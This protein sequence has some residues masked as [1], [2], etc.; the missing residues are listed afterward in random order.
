MFAELLGRESGYNKGR[1]G[2]MHIA[3]LE[4]G[5]FGAN[6]IVGAGSP[7]ACGAAHMFKLRGEARV[8]VPFFGDG[9]MNQGVLL[10]SLNL[11]V[12][13]DLPVVFVCEN[14]GYAIT[15]PIEEMAR[16]ELHVRAAG[17]GMAAEAVDGMDVRA[18][19]RAAAKAVARARAGGGP[20][21]LECRAY[22]YSLHNVAKGVARDDDRPQAEQAAWRARDAIE[23][24][25][26]ELTAERLWDDGARAEI[27][28]EVERELDGAIAFARNS[29]RPDPEA[30]LDHMYAV[31]YPGLPAWGWE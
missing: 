21:F 17:F 20:S 28:A 31:T 8:A 9:A 26:G 4:L 10:E 11:A 27:D 24:L 6:G 14:N 1:G 19:Y 18:V 15:S 12:V 7:M 30:A 2:S 3:D 25:A 22:R 16:G 13:L 23:R 5:I 29:R